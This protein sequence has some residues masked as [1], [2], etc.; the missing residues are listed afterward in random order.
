VKTVVVVGGD[1]FLGRPICHYLGNA[2][3]VIVW[4]VDRNL[5]TLNSQTL[6]DQRVDAI[7]NLSAVAELSVRF[8]GIDTRSWNINV[9]GVSHLVECA[10]EAGAAFIQFSTREVLGTVYRQHDVFESN[11]VYR[12]KWEITEAQATNPQNA[13]G[14]S[15]LISE[16]LTQ[17]L[18]NGYVVRLATPYSDEVPMV[19]GGLIPA[20]LRNSLSGKPVQLTQGGKQFRDP[21][22]A[23]DIAAL[24][25][26]L[27]T[28]QPNPGIYNCGYSGSNLISLVELVRLIDGD[29]PIEIVDGGD[30]GFAFDTT[31]A[32]Q[33]LGWVPDISIR[34]RLPKLIENTKLVLGKA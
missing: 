1:G 3:K 29:I 33:S 13:Y 34:D 30:L 21:V 12:P 24:V 15:K 9:Q 11:G 7:V 25:E 2:F 5:F 14:Q 27:I 10:K 22:H 32:R 4:D 31:H 8:L 20:L 17:T 26:R 28:L 16:W 23:L 19:G 18:A 6:R